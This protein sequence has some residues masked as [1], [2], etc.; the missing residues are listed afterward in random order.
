MIKHI[1]KQ[2]TWPVPILLIIRRPERIF[3]LLLLLST[4]MLFIYIIFRAPEP[5]DKS[6]PFNTEQY[7]QKVL[8]IPNISPEDVYSDINTDE[9]RN[10]AEKPQIP[11]SNMKTQE[12]ISKQV[13]CIPLF[14]L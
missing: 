13:I 3:L 14:S 1:E 9:I 4:L 10:V 5:I 8:Q 7:V 6:L 12:R 2:P 11:K